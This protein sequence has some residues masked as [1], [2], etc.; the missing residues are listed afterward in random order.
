[1]LPTDVAVEQMGCAVARA[2]AIVAAINP[3]GPVT[4][5]ALARHQLPWRELICQRG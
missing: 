4:R 5:A 1:L 2:H 3:R